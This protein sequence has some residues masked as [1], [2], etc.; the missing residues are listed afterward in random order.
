MHR[1]RWTSLT[2][3]EKRRELKE[4]TTSTFWNHLPNETRE[5]ILILMAEF[6]DGYSHR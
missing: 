1:K 3:G 2:P 4:I 5:N 6:T